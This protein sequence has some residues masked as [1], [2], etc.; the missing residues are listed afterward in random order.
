VAVPLKETIIC[1]VKQ[2]GGEERRDDRTPVDLQVIK[3]KKI[4]N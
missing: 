1:M 3:K 4:I 2:D